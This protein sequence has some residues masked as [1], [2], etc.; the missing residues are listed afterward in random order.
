MS[1]TGK[2]TLDYLRQEAVRF[3]NLM[4]TKTFWAL[5]IEQRQ[6]AI[7]GLGYVYL[8]TEGST[9]LSFPVFDVMVREYEK[10]SVLVQR[11]GGVTDE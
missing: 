10:R 8:H 7:E 3:M 5:P 1:E 11:L 9:D 4:G 2:Y 6:R